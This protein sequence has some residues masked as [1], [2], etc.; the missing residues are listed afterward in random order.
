MSCGAVSIRINRRG[1]TGCSVIISGI[2]RISGI[3]SCSFSGSGIIS[4]NDNCGAIGSSSSGSSII[5]VMIVVALLV[6][7]LLEVSA[8]VP[9][10]VLLF[11]LVLLVLVVI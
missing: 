1:A 2:I 7:V 11:I 9:P 3:V 4:N 5:S 10:A 6:V 8:V